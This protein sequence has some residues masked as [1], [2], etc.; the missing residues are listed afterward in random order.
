[1]EVLDVVFAVDALDHNAPAS[2]A[3][4]REGIKQFAFGFRAALPEIQITVDDLLAEGDK[5]IW[6]WTAGGTHQGPLMGIPT[7][8]KRVAFSGITI[9][10]P[11]GGEIVERWNQAGPLGL[12]QQIGAI[13]APA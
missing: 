12:L 4:G 3:P 1:L 10:R 2:T 5:V 7:S 13:P 11:V 8:A 9:D 6:R